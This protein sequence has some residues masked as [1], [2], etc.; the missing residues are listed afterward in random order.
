MVDE[1]TPTPNDG[2]S[3]KAAKPPAKAAKTDG[4]AAPKAKKEK[5]PALED[6]PFLDFIREYYLAALQE[7]LSKQGQPS[8]ELSFERQPVNVIGFN[9]APDCWQV[10]G[11]W[12]SSWKQPREFR[13][14]FFADDIQ[15][16]KGF[17]YSESGGKASTLESFL[18]DERKVNLGLLVFGVL[19]RLN[20]Q[21]W[22]VRN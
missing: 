22:L 11:R 2:S 1:N 9:Q 17:S 10:I 5:A 12:S 14:Y 4:E 8:I 19:Q 15:G 21:K 13:V 16:Q 18:I 6:K 20:A 7:A 3:A